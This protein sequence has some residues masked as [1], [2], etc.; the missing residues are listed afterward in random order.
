MKERVAQSLLYLHREGAR[1][2]SLR[3]SNVHPMVAT[4]SPDPGDS[5][6]EDYGSRS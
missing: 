6:Q 2:R 4:A 1:H 5:Q 3:D